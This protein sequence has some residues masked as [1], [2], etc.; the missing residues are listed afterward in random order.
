MVDKDL[1]PKVS[2]AYVISLLDKWGS[3]IANIAFKNP[4]Y[5][6]FFFLTKQVVVRG[7]GTVEDQGSIIDNQICRWQYC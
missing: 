2:S 3:N 1:A 4:I 6:F 7:E 5:F